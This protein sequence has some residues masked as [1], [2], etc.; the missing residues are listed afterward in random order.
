M[1]PSARWRQG[2]SK[3]MTKIASPA[4]DPADLLQFRKEYLAA[5]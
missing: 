2:G 1:T 4:V 5:P 3:F